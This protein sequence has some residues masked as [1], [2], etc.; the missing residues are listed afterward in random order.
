MKSFTLVEFLIYIAILA[1]ILVSTIGFL[2]T[3]VLGNIKESSF[4]E[5]QQNGRFALTE[6]IRE[7]RKATEIISPGP[8]DPPANSLSLAMA[9][10][11][12]T[13]I[14]TFNGKLRIT[15]AFPPLS[16]ELTSDQ[17]AISNLRFTNLSYP[18]TPGTIQIETQIDHIN[19][20]N[21]MEYRASIIL[22]STAS[23]MPGGAAP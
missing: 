21:R 9:D 22:K 4:Q 13:V 10:G 1:T 7:T 17:V 14:D 12:T 8:D 18:N 15:K 23:L 20:S 11:S 16:Y 6:I 5:V 2:W 3:M 19:P